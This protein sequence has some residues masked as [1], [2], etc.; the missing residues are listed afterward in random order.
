MLRGCLH[1]AVITL[2]AIEGRL[3]ALRLYVLL[4]FGSARL[5]ARN[6]EA[7]LQACFIFLPMDAIVLEVAGHLTLFERWH[8]H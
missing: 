3:Q 1:D 2:P 4:E 8:D 7:L 6:H 5:G